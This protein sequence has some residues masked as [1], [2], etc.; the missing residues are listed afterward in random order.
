MA[1]AKFLKTIIDQASCNGFAFQPWYSAWMGRDWESEQSALDYLAQGH[2][3]FSLLFSHDFARSYWMQG[4]RVT[5]LVPSTTY[6]MRGKNGVLIQVNRKPH[7]KRRL[8]PDAWKYHLREMACSD[9]PL[10]YVRRFV[11]VPPEAAEKIAVERRTAKRSV[12][13]LNRTFQ[14]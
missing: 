10:S 14:K 8:K 9:E 3:Y 5:F 7:T 13:S 12:F 11:L 4:T 2:N 1:R 6:T